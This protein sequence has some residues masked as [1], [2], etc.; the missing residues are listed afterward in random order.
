MVEAKLSMSKPK[1]SSAMNNASDYLTNRKI[2]K[3]G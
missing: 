3:K 2:A 1:I